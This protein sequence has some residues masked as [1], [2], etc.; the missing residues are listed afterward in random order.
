[1]LNDFNHKLVL[2]HG[3]ITLAIYI[4]VFSLFRS[5]TRLLRHTTVID[6][7]NLLVATTTSCTILVIFSIISRYA[8]WNAIFIIPLSIL[9]IH[10][11]LISVLLLLLRLAVKLFFLLLTTSTDT[12]KRVLIYGAG[13]AGIIVKRVI[14]S[15][16]KS[17]YQ[18][19]GFLDDNKKLHGKKLN[20]FPVINPTVLSESYLK[21]NKIKTLIFAI[22]EISPEDKSLIVRSLL[23][24]GLEVLD[25][26]PLESWLDGQLQINQIR[27]VKLEDLLGREPIKLDMKKIEKGLHNK[28][29]LITGAAGS[30][31]SEIVRQITRFSTKKL[32]L[33]D[34]A[35]TPV[36]H[37]GNELK[38]NFGNFP[39]QLILAD[40]THPEKLE[41]IFRE[42][43]PEVVFHAA[44]YKHVP[45]MEENPHEAIRVNIGGTKN[46]VSL[47]VQYD[48]QKFV[49]I[50]SDKAVN[51]TNIMGA[52][53]RVCEM[54]VQMKAQQKE[55]KTQFVITRFG[56]VLGSNGSVIPLFTKQ[57]EEGGPLTVTH[58]EIT[59]YF[60]TI[61]EA[62]QLV[63]EAGFM[64]KDNEIYVFDMGNPV[65][66]TDLANQMIRLSGLV[67]GKDI[68]IEYTGL[69][70][71]EKLFEELLTDNENTLATHHPKIKI[72][73]VESFNN[74]EALS[75]INTLLKN[76]YSLSKEEVISF[77][78]ELVP[79][80]RSN[81]NQIDGAMEYTKPNNTKKTDKT[82]LIVKH[83]KGSEV[84]VKN[85]IPK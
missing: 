76:L 59:R 83:T 3:L 72:A 61:P 39:A 36:F 60:M 55:N 2:Q 81:N 63:L 35:E 62:C 67:P 57:I 73:R 25:T 45:L 58:P 18:I 19:A 78:R 13:A 43:R 54:I 37:M 14:Q 6:I 4:L 23:D 7:F 47:S 79:E 40:I 71:G 75:R 77:F 24:L 34:Q 10:Y 22:K 46:L 70:P 30:I 50:S 17:G 26:P 29:I 44:A 80:Y 52:S 42:H 66:I 11:L 28:T 9:I 85:T 38:A 82:G 21:S 33:V 68:K 16:V 84:L 15:D 74:K 69:R 8:G 27:K 64:G 56:N 49:M 65:R 5:H 41:L 20:G 1:M 51:P 48:V 31:G 12:K 32:I 53:K